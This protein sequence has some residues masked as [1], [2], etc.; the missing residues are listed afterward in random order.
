MRLWVQ[1]YNFIHLSSHKIQRLHEA[2]L[3]SAN[4]L[5]KASFK[6]HIDDDGD[7]E[8]SR[9]ISTWRVFVY[10]KKTNMP[11]SKR[12]LWT[13]SNAHFRQIVIWWS[14]EKVSRYWHLLIQIFHSK[15]SKFLRVCT[16]D[17]RVGPRSSSDQEPSKSPCSN[18]EYKQI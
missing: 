15:K 8:M 1:L 12:I 4:S 18:C 13:W 5:N 2:Y 7:D 11:S 9:E 10:Q 6:H 14:A 3:H 16:R 17:H